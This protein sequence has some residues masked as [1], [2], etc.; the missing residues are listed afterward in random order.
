V[1]LKSLRKLAIHNRET[2]WNFDEVICEMDQLVELDLLKTEI[3]NDGVINICNSLSNLEVLT[4]GGCT[5]LDSDFLSSLH[6]LTLLKKLSLRAIFMLDEKTLSYVLDVPSLKSL[7]IS[8]LRLTDYGLSLLGKMTG[9]E[10]L[11]IARCS[12]QNKDLVHLTQLDK[13][14]LLNVVK[15]EQLTKEGLEQI[16]KLKSLRHIQIYGCPLVTDAECLLN[17]VFVDHVKPVPLCS[18]IALC[19]CDENWA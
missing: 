5:S 14:Q 8:F 9:L 13:L 7:D 1:Q 6:R 19:C 12:F 2:F 15:C 16:A 18:C 4:L 10:E 17:E 3:D 11:I